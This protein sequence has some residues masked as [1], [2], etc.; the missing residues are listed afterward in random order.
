LIVLQIKTIATLLFITVFTLTGCAGYEPETESRVE[1]PKVE[2]STAEVQPAEQ[3][4]PAVEPTIEEETE[5]KTE[6]MQT[7]E[8]EQ[9]EQTKS[10]ALVKEASELKNVATSTN[11][12]NVILTVE[13]KILFEKLSAD[14]KRSAHPTLDEIAKL[15]LNYPEQMVLVGGHADTLPTRTERFPSNWDL[16]AQRAVNVVKYISN[17]PE[18]DKSRL[19][20]AGFG[21]YHPVAPND[22]PEN[23]AKN[24][25][26]EIIILPA[27]LEHQQIQ[28]DY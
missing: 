17:L 9:R 4:K 27:G 6:A 23:R 26:V 19:V 20:A 13:S 8:S 11:G 5:T 14:I 16:S 15:L 2:M 21:E 1:G 24:R 25:R 28:L 18:L 10:I 3:E 7:A 12:K 22:T